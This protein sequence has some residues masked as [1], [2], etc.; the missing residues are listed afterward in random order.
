MWQIDHQDRPTNVTG[1]FEQI[2]EWQGGKTKQNVNTFYGETIAKLKI[3]EL[4]TIK[5]KGP[6]A[7][8]L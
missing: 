3:G 1:D 4:L 8:Y 5:K 7:N 2:N 6:I